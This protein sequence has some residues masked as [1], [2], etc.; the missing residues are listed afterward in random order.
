MS[1][2]LTTIKKFDQNSLTKQEKIVNGVTTC[3]RDRMLSYG[4]ILPS[5]NELSTSL[6]FARETVVKA[7]GELKN[8]GLVN[9]KQG[10]GYFVANETA[11][12][13][14]SIALVL[15]GFQTFQQD[16]YNKFRKCLGDQYHIDVFFHHNNIHVY[17]YILNSVSNKYGMYVVAPIQSEEA[18]ALLSRFPD[19]KLLIIDRYQNLGEK[20]SCIAQEFEHSLSSVFE[21]LLPHIQ[22]FSQVILYFKEGLDYPKGIFY[23]VTDFCDVFDIP[24]LVYEEFEEQHMK[25]DQL[26]FT[27]G[28]TDLWQ[29]LKAS[30]A[31]D[32]EPG[33]D[34][35]I[36]SHNDSPV[37]E[38]IAGGIT[39]FSTNFNLM[40]EKAA[41]FILSRNHTNMIIPSELIRRKS[42]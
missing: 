33:R 37:K 34:I 38:I 42:L 25:P 29:V 22:K 20:V 13:K 27:V 10:L 31:K 32:Y 14:L 36:L 19:D 11:D 4:D 39:T 17:E 41:A 6:G 28:D 1:A 24:L 16:F 26:F 9:S 2:L 5:V 7:Y 23:A 3:I 15:Y 18:Q 12:Q 21:S 35:G 30:N 40:A 8:R